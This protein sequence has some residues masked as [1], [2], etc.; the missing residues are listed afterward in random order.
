MASLKR[1]NG[2]LWICSVLVPV[3]CK[4]LAGMFDK[5]CTAFSFPL[6]VSD[7]SVV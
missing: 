6:S 1:S 5:Q 7:D 2:R 3:I 4:S